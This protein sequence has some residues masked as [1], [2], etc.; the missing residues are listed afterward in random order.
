MKLGFLEYFVPAD[1]TC[2]I[3]LKSLHQFTDF[4]EKFASVHRSTAGTGQAS[5]LASSPVSTPLWSGMIRVAQYNTPAYIEL[6]I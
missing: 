5:Y 3:F 1:H 6:L 4:F 2:E